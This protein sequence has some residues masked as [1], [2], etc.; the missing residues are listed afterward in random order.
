MRLFVHE[1][2]YRAADVLAQPRA[3]VLH[4]PLPILFLVLLGSVY[5][6]DTRST[7]CKGS[8]YLLAGMLGYGVASTA[9]AGL[10]ITL[11]DPA[12]GRVLKR[13][14]ATPLPRGD[15]HRGVLGSTLSRLT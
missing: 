5:G 4:V 2:R 1:L 9:F 8:S 7:A 13:V 3:R 14:R 6:N 10:A 12:R 15:L 11:V